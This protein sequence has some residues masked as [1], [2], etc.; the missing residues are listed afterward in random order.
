MKD[1]LFD[2]GSSIEIV[3]KEYLM[4]REDMGETLLITKSNYEQIITDL[5]KSCP[6]LNPK[7]AKDFARNYGGIV[8]AFKTYNEN[9]K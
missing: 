7:V 3:E 8:D 9:C 6:S 1:Q 2:I 5:F 4:F